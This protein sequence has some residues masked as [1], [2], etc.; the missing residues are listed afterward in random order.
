MKQH[1]GQRQT[2]EQMRAKAAWLRVNQIKDES[3]YRQNKGQ[4]KDK[5]SLEKE[6]R[7]RVRSL[8]AMI[9]INGLGSTLGFLKAKSNQNEVKE[10]KEPNAPYLFLEHLTKWMIERNFIRISSALDEDTSEETDDTE[11][12]IHYTDDAKDATKKAPE[13]SFEG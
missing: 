6:Y 12:L 10:G 4:D 3:K 5:G 8:N 11:N 9:Q 1:S 13:M 2:L 7:S